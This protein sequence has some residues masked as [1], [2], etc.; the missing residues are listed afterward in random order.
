MAVNT[1]FQPNSHRFK[2]EQTK[3]LPERDNRRATKVVSGNARTKKKSELSKLK[4]S[5]I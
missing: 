1:D 3:A 2:E 5:I 4:G